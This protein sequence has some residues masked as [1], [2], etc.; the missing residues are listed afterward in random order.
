MDT[1]KLEAMVVYLKSMSTKYV[2]P[3]IKFYS[4]GIAKG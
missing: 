2:I 3:L 1:P 4:K